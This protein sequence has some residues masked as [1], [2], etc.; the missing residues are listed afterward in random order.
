MHGR[1]AL[2]THESPTSSNTKRLLLICNPA[3][4]I[5]RT[6]ET[7]VPAKP[8]FVEISQGFVFS[9]LFHS[10]YFIAGIFHSS[11]NEVT[12]YG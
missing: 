12:E 6:R 9:H 4:E 2:Y 11:L 8:E 5:C 7:G 10:S 3:N 1:G